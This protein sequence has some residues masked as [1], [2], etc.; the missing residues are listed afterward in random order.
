[1]IKKNN[2]ICCFFNYPP[3]YRFPIYKAMSEEFDCE[4]YFGD[5]VFEPL[6]QFD[7]QRLK[8]F[9]S[10]LH[11]TKT[12]FKGYVWYS[13]AKKLFSLKYKIYI[14]TG[15]ASM[16]TN[17][18]IMLWAKIWRKK[19]Y[20]WTHGIHQHYGKWTTNMIYK[21][22]YNFP[23]GL[24]MY[25]S[26]NW[27]YMEELGCEKKQIHVIH[28]SL[29]TDLQ[30]QI[31]NTMHSSKIYFDH[32]G[33]DNPVVIYIGRLQKRKRVDQLIEAIGL[34]KEQ[35][36]YLN[37]VLVGEQVDSENL[38]KL[39]EKYQISQN[40]WFYGPSFDEIINAQLLYDAHVCVCPAAVGLT[41]IHALSYGCPVISND[42]A[43]T[44]MPEYESIK[45]GV[46]GSLFKEDEVGDLVDKIKLWCNR[47]LMQREIT[48]K[49]CRKVILD[50]WSIEY[51]I[52]VLIEI[53]R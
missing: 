3:H 39:V 47:D 51:Q 31:F 23:D 9:K 46:T 22:F 38:Q 11:A 17:W 8:G 30:T 14:L 21:V 35:G 19:V 27:K 53:L 42:N 41:A 5:S 16:I 33:N 24:L 10:F 4:F 48:R 13:N 32:F 20:L 49:E 7:V 18:L 36:C 34:A 2:K 40:V 45:E 43:E 26:Y 12:N 28:N 44:Q 52:K 29:D 25:S 1:M 15:D 37:L 6:K 50:E